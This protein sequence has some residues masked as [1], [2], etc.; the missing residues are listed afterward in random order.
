MAWK[1]NKWG[2]FPKDLGF[3]G[4]AGM[5]EVKFMA[6]GGK[7]S[8]GSVKGKP[9]TT[10]ESPAAPPGRRN[11]DIPKFQVITPADKSKDAALAGK[12][13]VGSPSHGK[14]AKTPGGTRM[15]KAKGGAV[16][17]ADGGGINIR[18]ED[19][20]SMDEAM[21]NPLR[22]DRIKRVASQ[23]SSSETARDVGRRIYQK[24]RAAGLSHE[25]ASDAAQSVFDHYKGRAYRKDGVPYQKGGPVKGEAR[26]ALAAPTPM[27]G[28]RK[29]GGGLPSLSMK[30]RFS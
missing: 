1:S 7:V 25:A 27:A 3:S 23:N 15:P 2:A 24:Q 19:L 13:F 4:S 17:K 28:P 14:G 16:R 6:R 8:K 9:D 29:R 12:S 11:T 10:G 30:P 22:F 21:G 20:E 18:G 26:G 5:R